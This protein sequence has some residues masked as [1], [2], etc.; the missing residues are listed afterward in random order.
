KT[1]KQIAG[2]PVPYGK[3]YHRISFAVHF[4][5]K[6]LTLF[7]ISVK[8]VYSVLFKYAGYSEFKNLC[9]E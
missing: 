6:L 4:L 7:F 1:E 9:T 8:S 5:E 2:L 3:T